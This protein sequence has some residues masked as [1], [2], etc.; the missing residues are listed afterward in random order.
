MGWINLELKYR[1]N[2][3]FEKM[4]DS[5]PGYRLIRWRRAVATSFGTQRYNITGEP[6]MRALLKII[7][8]IF[9]IVIVL[10]IAIAVIV[11]V[12]FHPN[13]YKGE[14]AA[15]I[16][17]KTGRELK[18][19]GDIVLSVFPWL[20]IE[21]GALELGNAPGFHDDK[22]AR[23]ER[24]EVG[25][26]L[27]PLFRKNLEVRT[28]KIHGLE[29][30]LAKDKNGRT[31]WEDLIALRSKG[32]KSD[33]ESDIQGKKGSKPTEGSAAK[34]AMPL[35]ILGVGGLDIQNAALRWSDAQNGKYYHLED[36]NIE[37]GAI[38]PETLTESIALREPI[39]VKASFA[40]E[41]NKPRISGHVD[42]SAKITADL[43]KRAFYLENLAITGKL[44]GESLPN[45]KLTLHLQANID[46]DLATQTMRAKDLVLTI[47]RIGANGTITVTRLLDEP[48]FDGAFQLEKFNPRALLTDLGRQVFET[49]DPKAITLASLSTAIQGTTNQIHLKPL[50]IRLD[51]TTLNGALTIDDFS[52]LAIRFDL[53]ADAIDADRYLPPTE[54]KQNKSTRIAKS[55]PA[56]PNASASR[57]IPLPLGALRTLDVQGKARI[58][59]LT[60]ANLQ[61]SD[62]S[63]D[64]NAKDGVI[65]AH[66]IKMNLYQGSYS[67]DVGIDARGDAIRISFDKQLASVRIAPL[68]RD[69][70]GD[71]PLSGKLWIA[72]DIDAAGAN[73]EDIKKTMTG[74]ANFKFEDGMVKGFD[75]V[76][77]ICKAAKAT[78]DADNFG[79]AV[80]AVLESLDTDSDEDI[81]KTEF[82]ELRGRLPITR[83]RIGINNTLALKAPLLRVNG[84]DGAIDLGKGRLDNVRFIVESFSSCKGQGGKE[85]DELRGL[86]IPIT[87]NGPMEAKSCFDTEAIIQS[88][89]EAIGDRLKEKTKEKVQEKVEK[90]LL[91]ELGDKL[92]DKLGNQATED[93]GKAIEGGIK[94]ILGQ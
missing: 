83:G 40:M 1:Q 89:I 44:S 35:A 58:G 37:T 61:L 93:F 11:P 7:G 30:N 15:V 33:Q 82:Q 38:A 25:V 2:L 51:E 39:D 23:L 46:T 10:F 36:L 67:G 18:I 13:D 91:E 86:E 21:L 3:V 57:T 59:K 79:E 50:A 85:L 34:P 43:I 52:T 80:G 6:K 64:L 62:L 9:G 22:F 4:R 56:A 77:M 81:S 60:I 19:E 45:G 69:F 17:E 31:N 14:I 63:L 48:Q 5:R 32:V 72:F 87:C 73:L 12:Y 53:Q 8:T 68:L 49:A 16:Q 70:Q 27:L 55:T 74:N 28:I 90:I 92:G 76:R 26:K 29:L 42:T 71:D 65:R 88:V 75:I 47:G 20:A 94:D 24:M 78:R 41:G 54:S 84:K 66:P